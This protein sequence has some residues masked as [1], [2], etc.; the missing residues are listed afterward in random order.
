MK[1]L[2]TR[3]SF[4]VNLTDVMDFYE[5]KVRMCANGSNMVQGQ[6]FTVSYAPTV[7]ADSFRLSLNISASDDMVVVFI[8][9]SND[10]QT[11][12]ISDPNKRI[13]VTLHTMNMEWFR[14]RFPNHSISICKNSKE[15]IMQSLRNI[16]GTKDAGYEWYQLLASIFNELEWKPNT[17]YKGVVVYIKDD[18]TAYINLATDDI[19]FMLNS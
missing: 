10:F 11:D 13:Y 3:L 8:D 14:A 5:I 9:A 7:D 17:T 1:V 2:P 4:E 6:D 18:I 19:L 16:Q 15:L 12:V